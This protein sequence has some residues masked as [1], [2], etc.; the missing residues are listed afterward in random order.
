MTFRVAAVF[1]T[2]ALLVGCIDRTRVNATCTWSDAAEGPLDLTVPADRAHLRVDA[3]IAD[4]LIV[5]YGD[6]HGPHR[7][8]LQRPYRDQCARA[9]LDSVSGRHSISRAQFATAERDRV[10][11]IDAVLVFLP[12]ALIGAA[13]TDGVTRRICRSFDPEDRLLAGGS[14]MILAILIAGVMLAVTNFW[15]FWVEEWRLHDGHLSNRAFLLP[16]ITHAWACA[17]TAVVICLTVG[18]VRFARTPLSASRWRSYGHFRATGPARGD[19]VNP[20]QG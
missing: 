4:E 11:W 19:G 6:A 12:M 9:M 17:I 2:A 8:D 15:S 5:R 18:I 13:A 20:Y 10:W 16:I 7:P 1:A 3:Q 14:T